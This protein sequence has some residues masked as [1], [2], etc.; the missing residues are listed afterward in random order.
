MTR[1]LEERAEKYYWAHQETHVVSIDSEIL[2]T[3]VMA[4]YEDG[5]REERARILGM[6]RSEEAENRPRKAGTQFEIEKMWDTG[7][8]WADYLEKELEK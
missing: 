1:E 4:C 8:G 3:T 5:A 7:K 6:L 2:K